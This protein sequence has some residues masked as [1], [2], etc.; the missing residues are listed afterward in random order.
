VATR[1]E[2]GRLC[3]VAG[4]PIAPARAAWSFRRSDR[5]EYA[6]LAGLC[7][8]M[9]PL[10]MPTPIRIFAP[11]VAS[12]VVPAGMAAVRPSMPTGTPSWGICIATSEGERGQKNTYHSE[13]LRLQSML[14][15]GVDSAAK[16]WPTC[17]SRNTTGR[18]RASAAICSGQGRPRPPHGSR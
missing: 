8:A 6:S 4:A 17:G 2:V 1:R 18:A 12:L 11:P 7:P 3:E 13:Q 15:T 16:V 10:L 5:L 14:G 9:L